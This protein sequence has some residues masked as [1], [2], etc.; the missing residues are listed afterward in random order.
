MRGNL[1]TLVALLALCAVVLA[2]CMTPRTAAQ[3]HADASIADQVQHVLL[4]DPNSY[5][6]HIDVVV[7][8]GVGDLTGYVWET[9]DYQT[10]RHDAASGPGVAKVDND[11]ELM[12][13]GRSGAGF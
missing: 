13:G 6:H 12:R 5:A 7:R 8:N 1:R 9:S 10:A 2:G 3:R 11:L 4:S